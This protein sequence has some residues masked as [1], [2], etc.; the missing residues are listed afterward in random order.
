MSSPP[1]SRGVPFAA[2]KDHILDWMA[3]VVG[4]P[5]TADGNLASGG[6][7]ASLTA[8]VAGPATSIAPWCTPRLTFTSVC[9][10]ALE[11][12]APNDASAHKG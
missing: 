11:A 9:P 4:F 3:G 6:S 2:A 7:I 12:G 8:I 10:K 1:S 5:A